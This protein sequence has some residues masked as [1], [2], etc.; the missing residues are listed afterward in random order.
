MSTTWFIQW[1]CRVACQ[2]AC[3]SIALSLLFLVWLPAQAI[4]YTFPGDIPTSCRDNKD[5]S[6][7]CATLGLAAGDTIVIATLT[8]ATITIDSGF[9][10]GAGAKINAAGTV[11]L[12]L[13][14][15][16]AAGFT[17]GADNIVN[18]NII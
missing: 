9:T 4:D 17:S 1:C 11:G 18:A 16:G 10:T 14:V 5:N 3:Q 12:N 7:S 13:A 8:T 15:L 2:R 6:F